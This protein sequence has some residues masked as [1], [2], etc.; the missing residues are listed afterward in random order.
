MSSA[1]DSYPTIPNI[2]VL[3]ERGARLPHSAS[4]QQ[5]IDAAIELIAE[6]GYSGMSV[7]ALCR[8]AGVVKSGLYWNFGS[9]EGLLRAVIEQVS[10][11]W[12]ED[13]RESAYQGSGALERLDRMLAELKRR[14]LEQPEG[15]RVLNVV[16][17]ERSAIDPESRATLRGF[18]VT[19]QKT[20][21]QGIVD[22]TGPCLQ[23]VDR[24]ADMILAMFDGIF[25]RY[26]VNQD[27]VDLER[28]FE[29]MR[30]VVIALIKNRLEAQPC[31]ELADGG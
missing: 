23:D 3:P 26:L 10:T 27:R 30:E 6:R 16:L 4:A 14:V 12:I 15:L 20:M 5:L 17:L 7:D 22:A 28:Q 8:R 18:F 2:S 9:K 1:L 29:G 21:V 11:E 31:G 19:A 24:V 13:I 25:L